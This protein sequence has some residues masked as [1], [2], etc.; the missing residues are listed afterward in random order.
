VARFFSFKPALNFKGRKFKGVRGFAGKPFHPPLTDVV[1]GAYT[2]APIFA[3]LG[4]L[5]QANDWSD[6]LYEASRWVLLAGAIA[7]LPTILTGFYDWWKST[8]KGTQAR[9][10]V[11]AHA[12][13]MVALSVIVILDLCVRFKMERVNGFYDPS[14][15]AAVLDVLVLVFVTIGGTIGG[16]LVFDWG[17]NV[18]VAKDHPVWHPSET[19]DYV[20]P[21][22]EPPHESAPTVES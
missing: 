10:M 18:E 1:V 4:F 22:D 11:N 8:P 20:S 5:F 17:F 15:T 16:D 21:H 19:N 14:A 12:W 9:R 7:S 2:I 6:D 13:M 3:L